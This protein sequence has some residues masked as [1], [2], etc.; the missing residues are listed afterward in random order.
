MHVMCLVLL[1]WTEASLQNI[2]STAQG[3]IQGVTRDGY[4]S[5]TGI[6]YAS[7][8]EG[9]GGRFKR[10]GIAPVWAHV[11]QP[12]E[13]Q[14]SARAAAE[15]CLQLDVHAPP[16]A[17]QPVLAW[18]AGAG[19]Y[20]AA[21]L[22]RE[23]I[24]V[25]IVRHRLGPQGFLCSS[26]DHIPGNAGVK[27]VLLA[28]RWIRDNIVAFNGNANNV[29]LGG[30]GFGAAIAEALT[31]TPT[32]Q[33]LFHGVILQSGTVLAPWAFNFDAD[34]RAKLLRMKF[35][36][37]KEI[38]TRATAEDLNTKA[39]QLALPYLPFGMCV[40]N[41]I[42]NEERLIPRSPYEI[43]SKGVEIAVPMIMGFN[44][45]EGYIF[46]S[47]L[48]EARV[49]RR[50]T[51]DM[52]FLLP[53]ELQS[54][55][56]NAPKMMREV[57]EMYF[58]NNKTMA[59]VLAYHR[60]AYFLSHIHRSV[61]FHASAP[62]PVYY[63]QFSHAGSGGVEEEPGMAKRGA[64]HSDEL[65]YLFPSKGRD[66]EGD[67]G[68]VQGHIVRLWTNFIKKLNPTPPNAGN[69]LWS[70]LNP[71]DPKVLD[72]GVELAMVDFPYRK[73]AQMWEDIYEKYYFDRRER[74]Y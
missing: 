15:E 42:K 24:I 71:H 1:Y 72:I 60:D 52:S 4:V 11:R 44:N 40:E 38:L 7:V 26:E 3:Q 31:L 13:C 27:D 54:N 9:A 10:G 30:Q 14:C 36:G 23:G 73:E 22:A 2:V 64:A 59:A 8:K 21:R 28:L 33:G 66:M 18:L 25:V 62:P 34:D 50:M 48:K 65:A 49:T 56:R 47:T 17:A 68:V 70:P 45:N 57:D 74:R 63:Y 39:D 32:A 12:H 29:V 6:P 20:D 58:A 35:N 46:V 19:P 61:M 51:K 41:S 53:V 69:T 55:K 37:S 16:G 43:L 67:D 5:Y